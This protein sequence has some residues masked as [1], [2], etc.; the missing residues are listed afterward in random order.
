MKHLLHFLNPTTVAPTWDQWAWA[1]L[2]TAVWGLSVAVV[3]SG[4]YLLLSL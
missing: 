4:V 3:C 1:I 2:V